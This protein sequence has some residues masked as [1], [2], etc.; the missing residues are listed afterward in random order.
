MQIRS[1]FVTSVNISKSTGWSDYRSHSVFGRISKIGLCAN[2]RVKKESD[3]YPTWKGWLCKIW[4]GHPGWTCWIRGKVATTTVDDR[5]GVPCSAACLTYGLS[6]RMANVTG[7][8]VSNFCTLPD[9][10]VVKGQKTLVLLLRSIKSDF[11]VE[12]RLQEVN[13]VRIL[14]PESSLANGVGPTRMIN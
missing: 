3:R 1:V 14:L 8:C 12:Y 9:H 6:E 11:Q 10:Q 13:Q 7:N 5:K 2:G 4:N